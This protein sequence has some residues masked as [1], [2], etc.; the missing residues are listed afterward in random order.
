MPSTGAAATPAASDLLA[1][2]GGSAAELEQQVSDDMAA[3]AGCEQR[4]E[5]EE[6]EQQ[7]EVEQE[8]CS[9]GNAAAAHSPRADPPAPQGHDGEELPPLA[10]LPSPL[11][12][13]AVV[14][15]A[16]QV[17]GG[18]VRLSR[19]QV[20]ALDEYSGQLALLAQVGGRLAGA[21]LWQMLLR[22]CRQRALPCAY[23]AWELSAGI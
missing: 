19:Q 11:Q 7:Q 15:L 4:Q 5:D 22:C 17:A 16:E 8:E 20:A 9:D 6:E 13:A 12:P 1:G 23:P 3:V 21:G 18:T 14:A 2:A 10:V